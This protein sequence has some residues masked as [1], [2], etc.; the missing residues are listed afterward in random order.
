MPRSARQIFQGEYYHILSRGN[1]RQR[2]FEDK[3]DFCFFLQRLL[4]GRKKHSVSIFHYCLMPNH[5][6]LL[7]RSEKLDQGISR[8][9]GEL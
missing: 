5:V 3:E 6:H 1:N 7:M 4:N 9:I 2:L 8:L